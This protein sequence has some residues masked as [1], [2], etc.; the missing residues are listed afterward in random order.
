MTTTYGIRTIAEQSLKA[1]FD[2]NSAMLP[3]V[4]VNIGQTGEI[5]TIPSVILYAEGADSHPN[6]G[7]RPLGN[8]ELSI[9]IYVYS[10]A[11]DAPTEAEALALHRARVEAVQ[12]IM[13][14]ED[15]LKAAW[16]QGKLYRAWLKS[17][18]E[19]MSDRRYGNALTYTAVA[20]YPPA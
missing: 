12:S 3:G 17:D 13:Q 5:R 16:T 19:G 4:Q 2:T 10:S 8:F 7:S 9:K 20:V 18:D 15:G 11:D 14:D 6:F 1:W